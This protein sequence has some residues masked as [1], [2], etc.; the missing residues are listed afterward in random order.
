[1]LRFYF[2]LKLVFESSGTIF[3]VCFKYL[4]G[5]IYKN[6]IVLRLRQAAR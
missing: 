1:M 5:W 3:S 6:T 2:D 4:D